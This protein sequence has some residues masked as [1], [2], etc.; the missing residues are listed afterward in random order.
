[1]ISPFYTW[2]RS[3][4]RSRQFAVQAPYTQEFSLGLLLSLGANIALLGAL[5]LWGG[6]DRTLFALP[7]F[8]AAAVETASPSDA[9]DQQGQT[10]EAIG[11]TGIPSDE[12]VLGARHQW[13][14]Q[15]WVAQL[16]REAT[17]V[18]IAAPDDLHVLLGDSISLWFPHELLPI[19]ATW[20]NQGISGEGT[21][22]LLRRLD[23]IADTQPQVLYL[24]IG[25]NDLLRGVEDETLL[26]N[27]RQI[28]QDLKEMHPDATIV[29]Q[30]ILPHAGEG[31][32]WEGKDQLL[33]ISNRRIR[34]L[35]QRL[36]IVADEEDIEYLDLQ[37]I[38]SDEAGNLRSDLS[39][40]GLH[41]N[42]NGY[43]AWAS[44]LQ[45]HRDLKL[46]SQ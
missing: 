35:N 9:A 39:T 31:I 28:I 37:S 7:S 21:L 44:A 32:T 42:D 19:G 13:S 1:M 23:L 27:Q 33:E 15:E 43:R 14:Y 45:L 34:E 4:S 3:A 25:I 40:D 29:V 17:A 26:A 6:R 38:F 8:S 41:L 36:A 12:P 30:T 11:G 22:G 16:E 20:L 2:R 18:A 46:S 24:M 5:L 10:G